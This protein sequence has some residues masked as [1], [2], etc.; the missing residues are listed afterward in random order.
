MPFLAETIVMPATRKANEN[1]WFGHLSCWLA[2]V[3]ALLQ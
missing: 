3:M 2:H 1:L